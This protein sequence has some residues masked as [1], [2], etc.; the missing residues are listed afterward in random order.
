MPTTKFS[1]NWGGKIFPDYF[2]TIRLR[3]D[4]KYFLHDVHDITLDGINMGEAKI[5]AI[6]TLRLDGIRD[7]LSLPTSGMNAAKFCGWLKTNYADHIK[8]GLKPSTEMVHVVYQWQQRNYA[9][10]AGYM[11]SF[12][13]QRLIDYRQAI[14]N[15]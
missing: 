15:P 12:M 13:E 10:H 14:S 2:Q 6:K 4:D 5:V 8:D 11:A 1:S 9:A 3:D 7:T